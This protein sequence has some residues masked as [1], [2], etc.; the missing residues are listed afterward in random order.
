M[1][2]IYLRVSTTHQ[3]NENQ[4]VGIVAYLKAR[5]MDCGTEAEPGEGFRFAQDTVSSNQNWR[6]HQIY[7]LIHEGEP[8]DVIYVAEVTRLARSTLEI[9]EIA[10]DAIEKGITIVAT[11]SNL[12][13]DGSLS[14]TIITTIL[15]LAGQIEKEFIRARTKEAL[16]RR[17]E[18]GL[19]LGRP[20][21]SPGLRK[22]DRRREELSGLLAAGLSNKAIAKAMK[23]S[24]NTVNSY[25]R[26]LERYTRLEPP[27]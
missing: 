8:G 5:G 25:T 26:S 27:L 19:P 7:G 23:V 18:Q 15:A 3:D 21:G 24:I 14:S 20:P 4:L 13:F 22:L 12:T 1:N 16:K 6:D 10:R 11:K 9:L 2:T 17:R